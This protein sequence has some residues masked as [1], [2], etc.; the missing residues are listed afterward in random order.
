MAEEEFEDMSVP[1]GKISD[2]AGKI[3]ES[4]KAQPVKAPAQS[5]EDMLAQLM[6]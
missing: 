5:D 4:S 3:S 1:M 2:P 6:A